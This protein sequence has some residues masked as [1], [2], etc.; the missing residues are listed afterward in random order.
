MTEQ[1]WPITKRFVYP[2]TR[3]SFEVR[4]NF[5]R[6]TCSDIYP[7]RRLETDGNVVIKIKVVFN[8]DVH[9]FRLPNRII[10]HH[11]VKTEISRNA[12]KETYKQQ[13]FYTK[14]AFTLSEKSRQHYSRAVDLNL[15]KMADY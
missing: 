8:G 10:L 7:S 11:L 6:R 2:Q 9:A 12:F 1:V 14:K 4:T 3:L 13:K 15:Y 5:R